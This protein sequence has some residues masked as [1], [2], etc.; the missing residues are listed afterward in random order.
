MSIG[1]DY[2][3]KHTYSRTRLL[4]FGGYAPLSGH[5]VDHA[6]DNGI[7]VQAFV[8][9][10]SHRGAIA[11]PLNLM[12]KI[13]TEDAALVSAAAGYREDDYLAGVAVPEGTY[14]VATASADIEQEWSSYLVAEDRKKRHA[15]ERAALSDH[16]QAVTI[17][18][19]AQELKRLGI[20]NFHTGSDIRFSLEEFLALAARIPTEGS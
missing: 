7:R 20:S 19:V 13:S 16:R 3:V 2:R 1:S 18:A 9:F 10:R 14:L 15:L 11:K 4:A 12:L 5:M 17:P 8:A 6:N